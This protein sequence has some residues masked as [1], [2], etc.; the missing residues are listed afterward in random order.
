METRQTKNKKYIRNNINFTIEFNKPKRIPTIN[1]LYLPRKNGK[2]FYINP[3]AKE[4]KDIVKE[5][6]LKYIPNDFRIDDMFVK[7]SLVI[8]FKFRFLVRDVSNTVKAIEDSVKESIKIDDAYNLIVK[9]A[10][11][12]NDVNES[13]YISVNIKTF[14]R[15][16]IK[17][18]ISEKV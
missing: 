9:E 15:N 16:S 10:K 2:G 11:I 4:I 12:F 13:E 8:C 18:K 7:L 5:S 6:T 14:N 17:W 3:K 1:S